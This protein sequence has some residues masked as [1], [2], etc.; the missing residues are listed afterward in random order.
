MLSKMMIKIKIFSIVL[1]SFFW[2]NSYAQD[3]ISYDRVLEEAL[4]KN[5]FINNELL[6][7]DLAKG[8]YYKTNNFFPKLPEL[9]FG[10]ETDKFYTNDGSKLFNLTLSQEIEI[11][12]QFS[13]R[14]DISNYRIR[15]SESEYKSRNYEITYEIKSILNN[16]ITLQLKLQIAKEVNKINE[17]LLYN[18]EKRLKAGDISE[19][20]YN[21]VSIEASNSLVNLGKTEVEFKNEVSNINVYLGYEQGK[22][23]YVNVD[24][25]Y[26]RIFLTLEQLKRAALENRAEIKAKQY[27]KLATNSE[28]SLY[29]IEIIP[30]LKLSLGYSNG[31]TIIP[32]DDIIGQHSITKIQDIDKFLNFGIG[33]SVPLPFNGLFNYNQGNIKVAE[34]RT[35]ILNNEIELLKKEINSEV[36]SGYNKWENSKKNVELLQRN[37]QV[38]EKT[39][40]LLK[41]GYEKGEL[42]LINYLSE[43]QK[44]FEMKLKY[45]DTLGEY[46]QSIIELEKVTQTKIY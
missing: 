5:L 33:F 21:L 35:K 22:I 10:Y 27:E 9:D 32:G 44:L 40:E 2:M 29:K 39:L 26:K 16:L 19:L 4:K 8:E 34:V 11:A 31:T 41:R 46:N 36:I 42:S 23:F 1:L 18:S 13:K 28:I 7:I 12:G 17:E 14:N 43:Q 30:S 37:N 20:E 45:I 3:T 24:T 25:A 38:I 15:K 6:N